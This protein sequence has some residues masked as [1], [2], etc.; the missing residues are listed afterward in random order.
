[1]N[2]PAKRRPPRRLDD[3]LIAALVPQGAHVLDLG[4]GDG[5]LLEEL[6][7]QRGCQGRGIDI[8]EAAVR[9]CIARG[10][11]VYH[12]DMME[13]MAAYRDGTFDVVILSQTLQQTHRPVVVIDEML[14]VG[15]RAIISFPNFGHWPI[16]WQLLSRGRMPLNE[17]LP[18]TWHDTPNVH[19]CTVEDFRALCVEQ[20]YR[21]VQ[22]VFVAGRARRIGPAGANWRA[23][24]AIF[25][26][27]QNSILPQVS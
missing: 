2:P 3:H 21:V 4:C 24:V 19:L 25:E 1:M 14:R 7:Q 16:R 9:A 18:Y 5:A 27:E 8:D 11:P 15:R 20:G 23:A 26:V 6:V 12:G 22:E 13:G 10:L 17:R